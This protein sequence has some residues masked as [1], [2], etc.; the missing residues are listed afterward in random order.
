MTEVEGIE[1]LRNERSWLVTAVPKV[2]EG[3]K[4]TI[5]FELDV[6]SKILPFTLVYPA[7]FP[8]TPPS[9]VPQDGHHYSNHQYG[10]GGELCLEFRSDNWDPS[11]SGSMMIESTYRLLSGEQPSVN[12]RAEVPSAHKSTLG[13][14]LR[15]SRSRFLLTRG[16]QEY[17]AALPVGTGLPCSVGVING[18][19]KTMTSFVSTIAF[20][21]DQAWRETSIPSRCANE[22]PAILVRVNS[23][24]NP[25]PDQQTL[26]WLIEATSYGKTIP[27]KEKMEA[28][29]TILSDSHSARMYLSLRDR[30][31]WKLI[32]FTTIDLN[33]D[34]ERLPESYTIL[35]SKKVGLV[36]CGSLGSKIAASLARSGVRSFVLV[37]DDILIPG[38]L[39]R[40]ELDAGSIGAHKVDGLEMRL[41]ALAPDVN[42]SGRSVILGGQESSAVT[43]SVLDELA[44]CDLL[45]DATAEPQAFNFV[46]S[47]AR[48]ALLPMIWAEIYAGGIGGFVARLRPD[49]ES[50]PHTARRQ[51]HSWC[52]S[53]G[54]PWQGKDERYGSS[55][56]KLPPVFADDADV[57][58]IAAHA[59][60]MAVD[61]LIRPN[62]SAF[63]NPGYVIGLS[64]DWI[65][66]EP[67]DTIPIKF[68]PEG[69]WRSEINALQASETIEI[70]KPLLVKN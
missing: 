63:P 15:G 48:R 10:Q 31:T 12:Q 61:V 20:D 52:R 67:F 28:R 22:F 6:N 5:D 30:D 36:G 29:I 2:I 64:A 53:Q 50:D 38:N 42:I 49:F 39:T 21:S 16:F 65:F 58:V 51:Y 46:A 7:L 17:S 62:E 9:V 8:E 4:L 66:R 37:D 23:L 60:R 18:Q 33:D 69:A 3:L 27:A 14:Y 70:L 11:V 56:D 55:R 59:S 25:P 40:H 54:M 19:H 35:A 24:E 57:T 32:P 44:T 26:D 45:I 34:S 47:V 68:P 1:T 43:A 13:Q 41:C